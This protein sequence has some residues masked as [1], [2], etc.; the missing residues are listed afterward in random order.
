MTTPQ[1]VAQMIRDAR[2][3][4]SVMGVVTAVTASPLSISV[5]FADGVDSFQPLLL[6]HVTTPAVGDKCWVAPMSGLWVYAGKILNPVAQV[7]YRIYQ[8]PIV[9]NWKKSRNEAGTWVYQVDAGGSSEA[10]RG[11]VLQGRHPVFSGAAGQVPAG[12]SDWAG[13]LEHATNFAAVAAASGTIHQ[14]TISLKRVSFDSGPDLVSPVMY[15]HPYSLA[16]T[17]PTVGSAPAWVGGYGPLR[18]PPIAR[19]EVAVYTLPASWVTAWAAGT[20][21][22]IGFFSDTVTDRLTSWRT[23][24]ETSSIGANARVLITYTVPA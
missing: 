16:G 5:R 3:P 22:G 8:A 10:S 7:N 20:I 1:T 21:K 12:Y 23:D 13:V 19:G 18:L 11:E 15:G 6:S 17:L 9:A 2:P 14:V 4:G 24:A